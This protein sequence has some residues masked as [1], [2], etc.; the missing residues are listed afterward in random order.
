M[1]HRFV[2]GLSE[3]V[4]TAGCGSVL[5]APHLLWW[6]S[7]RR[8]FIFFVITLA[9]ASAVAWAQGSPGVRAAAAPSTAARGLQITV[10]DENGV[11][12]PLARITLENTATHNVIQGE[13]DF[14]GRWLAPN[15]ETGTY[16][17]HV[18]KAGFYAL[19]QHDVKIAPADSVDVAIHHQQEVGEVVNVVDSVPTLDPQQT[20]KSEALT[21]REIVEIPYPSTR[22][23]R[24]IFP[25]IPGIVQDS[26]LAIHVAGAPSYDNQDVLDGF[27]I[28][29]PANG[30]FQMRLPPEAVRR[31]EVESSRYSAQYGHASAGVLI[32]DTK[33]GDDHFRFSGVNFIPTVQNVK[34][35]NFNNWVPRVTFSGPLHRG[36]AWFYGAHESEYDQIIVKELPNGADRTHLWRTSDLAKAQVNVSSGNVL[37]FEFLGNWLTN[38]HAGLDALDAISITRRQNFHSYV[39]AA[40][41]QA[42]LSKSVLLEIGV[43][44]VQFRNSELP[45]GSG[46]E[47]LA[48]GGNHGNYFRTSREDSRR[49]QALA[50]LYLP[51]LHAAGR[52]ELRVGTEAN[53]TTYDQTFS[54]NPVQVLDQ[55]NVLL[56]LISFSPPVAFNKNDFATGAYAQDRWSLG[57]RLVIEPGVRLDWDQIVRQALF[58]PRIAGTMMVTPNTKL[59]A[60]VG[61]FRNETTLSFL[62]APLNGQRFDQFY[63][64]GVPAGP[65]VV[66]QFFV[67]AGAVQAPESV[68]WSIGVERK[69]PGAIGARVEF[70]Q[71]AGIHDFVYDNPV[72]DLNGAVGGNYFLTSE[73]RNSYHSVQFTARRDFRGRYA[74]LGS[75]GRSSARSN[76]ALDVSFDNPLFGRQQPGPLPWDAPNRFVS[77]GFLP[78]PHFGRLRFDKWDLAY[79]AEWRTGFAFS[80]VN[81]QQALVGAPNGHRFPDYFT[82]NPALERR[83][84]F[85]RYLWALRGE[86]NNA[87]GRRN[88]SFVDPNINSPTFGQFSGFRGRAFEARIRFLGKEAA[89]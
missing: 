48:P 23:I 15:V 72:A 33:T 35:I 69:L 89:P 4:R 47:V 53:R 62:T 8:K 61:V 38:R 55:N 59:S 43:A 82:L 30:T 10:M 80:Y 45:Q 28:M 56:R 60:G 32:L 63:A 50:N 29:E 2:S 74:I 58:S 7:M 73:R 11:V 71:R 41:D 22:D 18:E 44:V 37:S 5:G 16:R 88:P 68:N 78:P 24:N 9:L 46:N 57:E 66:T 34:G 40:K 75:Y 83:F 79:S 51:T 12:A 86:M 36:R 85:H 27:S 64:N 76:A 26:T 14:S 70:I 17:I 20:A 31:V 65:A 49:V 6:S 52:H 19:D 84:R 77:W 13:T 42:Y 1:P 3:N 87:T 25:F 81:A 39:L 67:P 21:T 54:R